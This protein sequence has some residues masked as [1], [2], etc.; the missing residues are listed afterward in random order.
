MKIF[1]RIALFLI[2]ILNH[3]NLYSDDGIV[4]IAPGKDIYELPPEWYFVP[5]DT[6]RDKNVL[7]FPR[8]ALFSSPYK[9]WEDKKE[10]KNHSGNAWFGLKVFITDKNQD[11]AFMLRVQSRGVQVYWNGSLLHETTPFDRGGKTPDIFGKP[12]FVSIPVSSINKGENSLLFRIGCINNVS[13]LTFPVLFGE[14]KAIQ[15][16]WVS[17]ILWNGILLSVNLFLFI[18]FVFIFIKRTDEK[19]YLYFS[20]LALSLGLWILGYTGLVFFLFEYQ[21]VYMVFTYLGAIGASAMLVNFLCNFLIV[22][23]DAIA[24]SINLF[25][26]VL[27]AV[28]IGELI[29]DR[30]FHYFHR[31][32]LYNFIMML[33]VAVALY[34]IYI[35]IK[36]IRYR[37]PY[38][39]SILAGTSIYL[40]SFL[41]SV[42]FFLDITIVEPVLKEGGFVMIVFFAS[43]IGSRIAQVHADLEKSYSSL[44]EINIEK[45]RAIESLNIYK[46]IVSASRDLIAFIDPSKRFLE[47]NASFLKVYNK[48]RHEVINSPIKEIF[49]LEE[50]EY[51]IDEHCDACL[52]GEIV[53][54]ERWRKFPSLGRR[55]MVTTLYPYIGSDNYQTGIVYYS[56][57]ITERIKLEQEMV[58]ITENERDAIGMELHDNLAQ[59]LFGIA[60]KASVLASDIGD[61][62]PMHKDM[63]LEIEDLINKASAY[64]RTIAKSMLRMDAEE[65]GFI[66]SIKE[67]KRLLEN[68]YEI[69]LEFVFDGD[70]T[71][72]DKIYYSQIY[73][74]IQ[75]AVTNAVKHSGARIIKVNLKRN[76]RDIVLLINDDGIGI[77]DNFNNHR[78][79]GLQIMKYRARMIGSSIN[80]QKGPRGGTE[81]MC[82]IPI[83]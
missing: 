46:Y 34:C 49:G 1:Y 74:I 22:K 45:D 66:N 4:N 16:R 36:G 62:L 61:R 54:F 3:Q 59:K 60:L 5:E 73:Y 40:L 14:Y 27:T 23:K 20:I 67:L 35:C 69:A 37:R 53:I 82:V 58:T 7:N 17:F 79:I 18:Y 47:V 48:E 12:S 25:C 15:Q 81:V 11:Y 6:M 76:L 83:Y 30:D 10:I 44:T 51:S 71:L 39:K 57:D 42:P 72:K 19:Y 52:T 33:G 50:Y 26:I 32:N 68:R 29:I 13:P 43:A 21:M 2:V 65:G 8:K 70:L 41:L 80:I 56:M 64:T 55:F 77:S 24:R 31:Y 9:P 28:L 75:E 78:G 38:S 63:A